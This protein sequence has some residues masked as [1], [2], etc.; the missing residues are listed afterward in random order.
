VNRRY[1]LKV[2]KCQEKKTAVV[3][4]QLLV[5][6]SWQ[7]VSSC[8]TTDSWLLANANTAGLPQPLS[9]H[10]TWLRQTFSYFPNW[11]PLWKDDDFRRF[12]RSQKIRRQS[13]TWSLERHTRTVSRSGN[14]VRSS[15]S[16]QEG[17]TLKVI[18]LTQ[19]EAYPKKLWKIVRNFL[20][21]R[22]MQMESRG[23]HSTSLILS[24]S[25]PQAN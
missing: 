10:L 3:E 14:G 4:K 13:Y 25:M 5:P 24:L 8:I 21:R 15:A 7:C 6:P 2:L 18:R 12:K 19:L 20:D 17:S 23:H 16:V 1:F 9:T 11:N 22:C